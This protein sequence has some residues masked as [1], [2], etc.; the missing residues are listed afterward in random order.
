M[1]EVPQSN[2]VMVPSPELGDAL[3]GVVR[4]ASLR[5]H[6][7]ERA[8]CK[9]RSG[10]QKGASLRTSGRQAEGWGEGLGRQ[11][12]ANLILISQGVYFSGRQQVEPQSGPST[13][14]Q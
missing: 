7:Q 12:C 2:S 8:V 1:K 10:E 4:E 5:P 9:D 6:R 13:N 11:G 3:D 14:I